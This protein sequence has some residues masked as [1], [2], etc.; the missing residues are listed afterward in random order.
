M[1]DQ[2]K[3]WGKK[4]RAIFQQWNTS[5][6]KGI[7][8][9][10]FL[11]CI[12]LVA[13]FILTLL[14]SILVTVLQMGTPKTD[15]TIDVFLN[16]VESNIYPILITHSAVTVVQNFSILSPSSREKNL[17]GASVHFGGTLLVLF[18]LGIYS[19]LVPILIVVTPA[20]KT[21]AICVTIGAL[22]VSNIL[23]IWQIDKE[24][25]QL[26][27]VKKRE[28]EVQQRMDQNHSLGVSNQSP[29]TLTQESDESVGPAQENTLTPV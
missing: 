17:G 26:A 25:S 1:S 27:R 4:P 8:N 13:T 11:W 5:R 9:P 6:E 19:F 28:D 23:S 22:I 16:I 29:T 10:I 15:F 20:W 14:S 21:P 24:L 2:R 18:I 12:S 3:R 7:K